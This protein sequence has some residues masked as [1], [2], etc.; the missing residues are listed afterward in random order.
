V[1]LDT[2][3]LDP[4]NFD[5][6]RWRCLAEQKANLIAAKVPV[7]SSADKAANALIHLVNYYQRREA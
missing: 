7:Y 5:D 2:G 1:V 3:A 4:G 6:L